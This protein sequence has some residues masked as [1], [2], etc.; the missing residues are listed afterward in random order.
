LFETHTIAMV[1]FVQ[2][3]NSSMYCLLA[4]PSTIYGLRVSSNVKNIK[5]QKW[6]NQ[7]QR[8]IYRAMYVILENRT[9]VIIES[10]QNHQKMKVSLIILISFNSN[11]L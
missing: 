1:L 6:K 9:D 8:S 3:I 11:R 10:E 4:T 2:L 7:I 5:W